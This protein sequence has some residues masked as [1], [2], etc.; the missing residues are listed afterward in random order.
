MNIVFFGTPYFAK[1]ILKRLIEK[2][3]SIVA[4]ITQPDRPKGRSKKVQPPPVKEYLQQNG[5]D[6]P[7]FQPE[8]VSTSEMEQK[9][10]SFSPDLFLV[11]GYG[12][13]I[14]Q[15]ILDIPKLTC[16]NIHT[17]LLPKYRGAAPI[18]R[19]IESGEKEVGITLIEMVKKMDAGGIY[20]QKA[21]P[22]SEDEYF[23]E[24]ENKLIE[25]AF[26]L[27]EELLPQLQKK[28][29]KKIEQDESKVSFAPKI[30]GQD[31]KINWHKPAIE[32]LNQIRAYSPTPGAY[33]SYS[34]G[35]EEKRMKVLKAKIC[36][37]N[38][39]PRELKQLSKT[40]FAIGASENAIEPILVIPEG[41]KEMEFSAF[42]RGQEKITIL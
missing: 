28:T 33:F 35:S 39:R 34:T 26:Q 23:A 21:I 30:T 5:F 38:M 24:I 4:V 11:V 14:K 8:K 13:I 3:Y 37:E 17:S 29:A 15:F 32:I 20:A 1:E 6:I 19:A 7:I 18:Q 36:H 31:L 42:V 22:I 10:K 25:L 41:K 9:L 40:N 12:E 16:V 27:V 2:N